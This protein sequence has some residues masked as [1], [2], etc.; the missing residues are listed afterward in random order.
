[1]LPTISAS[2]FV[3][4]IV[5]SDSVEVIYH[6]TSPKDVN[7]QALVY[8]RTDTGLVYIAN[9]YTGKI[10]GLCQL[11][12]LHMAKGIV[13]QFGITETKF[14]NLAARNLVTEI[15]KLIK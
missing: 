4:S 15:N 12:L 2:T 6:A 10:R 5:S 1:M 14:C 11:N 7:K 13:R 8:K 3:N 9:G